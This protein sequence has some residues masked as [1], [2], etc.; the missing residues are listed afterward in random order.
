MAILSQAEIAAMTIEERFELVDKIYES[1]R[2]VP[3]EPPEWHTAVL[4]ARLR[5]AD[6]TPEAGIPW[7]EVKARLEKK[8]LR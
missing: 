3:P 1:F 7:E 4:E 8:W 6:A 2:T 5:E